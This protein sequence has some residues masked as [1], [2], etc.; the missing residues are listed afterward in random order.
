MKMFPFVYLLWYI[1]RCSKPL[2]TR[3]MQIKTTP[4]RIAIMCVCV[5]VCVWSCF[6]SVRLCDHMD[7]SPPGPSVRG[8]LQA[9]ILEWIAMPSSRVSSQP[10]DWTLIFYVSCI[11][12]WV[13]YHWRYLGSPYVYI[14]IWCVY[15]SMGFDVCTYMYV[16]IFVC[17]YI[18]NIYGCMYK[19]QPL[20]K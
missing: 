12:S 3:E 17:V 5:C 18:L 11:G 14:H 7:C 13:P 15:N 1:K 8:I 6:S 16:Y 20:Q 2:I 9:R 4:V 19:M 10:R